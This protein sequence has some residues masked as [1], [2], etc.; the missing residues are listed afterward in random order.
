L[1]PFGGRATSLHQRRNPLAA[2]NVSRWTTSRTPFE[3]Y[4]CHTIK[5]CA[6]DL[7]PARAIAEINK[8]MI[9]GVA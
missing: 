9:D 8:M 3:I 1:C 5:S 2:F 4:R 6:K 7:V